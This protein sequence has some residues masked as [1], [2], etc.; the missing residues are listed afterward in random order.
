MPAVN[1]FATAFPSLRTE[2]TPSDP[3]QHITL[4]TPNNSTDLAYVTRAI[5]FAVT[6]DIKVTTLGGETVIIP[7]GALA[8]GV[9]HSMQL[10]RIWATGT[11]A[12]GIVAYD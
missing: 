12:T 8:A 9:Q 4:V 1:R 3:P 5:S 10:T 6:G 11:A 7:S 2:S